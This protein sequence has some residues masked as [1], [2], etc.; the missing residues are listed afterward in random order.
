MNLRSKFARMGFR[1]KV[2]L[3]LVVC[4]LAAILVTTLGAF[5]F[6]VRSLGHSL[7]Q[8]H[9]TM[10]LLIADNLSAAV[11][12]N[13]REAITSILA[14]LE[15]DSDVV[16]ARVLDLGGT[17]LATVENP[18][19]RDGPFRH[20]HVVP[21]TVAVGTESLGLLEITFDDGPALLRL[22][23]VYLGLS[24]L[25]AAAAA[26]IA[27]MLGRIMS[28][29]VLAPISHLTAVA[30]SISEQGDSS[31]RA[32]LTENP[33]IDVLVGALNRMLDRIQWQEREL[34]GARDHLARQVVA[35]EHE[36]KQ[37]RRIQEERLVIE[38]KMQDSQRLE[39]LG[40]LAGG[41]A[42]DFNNLLAAILGN[43]NLAQMRLPE[44]SPVQRNLKQIET[45]STRAAELCR[46]MLAYAGRGPMQ[47]APVKVD[48][49][50]RET[51][52][53]LRV[54]IGA[55]CELAITSAPDLPA[56]LGDGSQLRQI[57]LNLVVNAAE[58]I[59]DA[60]L[61]QITVHV[62]Q[63]TYET[64]EFAHARVGR[65]LTTG[66]FVTIEVADNGP[67]MKA[68]VLE[69]IFEPF[70]STKFTGRG[71]GLA[72][73]LG[74]IRRHHGALFVTSVPGGG[75]TFRVV[76]P[77]VETTVETELV[78]HPAL[79]SNWRGSGR[80]LVVDDEEGARQ[81]EADFVEE[82]GFNAIVAS[83]GEEALKR[84]EEHRGDFAA[85][86]LDF[87]LPRMDGVELASLLRQ[88]HP[89]LP[90]LL[91]SGYAESSAIADL[92]PHLQR[93]FLSKPFT[94]RNFAAALRKTIEA[95]QA[96]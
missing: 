34:H 44:G 21:E 74:I 80:V 12:F 93:N 25:V 72:A 64:V 81:A 66:T 73:T 88:R 58:A 82:L 32:P 31:L 65:E 94:F 41:V 89:D 70:F 59:G 56:V 86:V 85:A 53:L 10:A 5:V 38:R 78:Q 26:G 95:E 22:S 24:A 15:A 11:A 49:L 27:I 79:A 6:Q 76:L 13:D 20:L 87:L 8:K 3:L 69:R 29:P 28:E 61:G 23:L 55:D 48:E 75:S 43:A 18:A 63:R 68:D 9:H 62:S 16:T 4:S 90:V 36:I 19:Y 47:L 96:E 50:V 67:G 83:S 1:P 14:S 7:H 60:R 39:S 57:V 30:H 42:H 33:D 2:R 37:R 91:L 45:I 46:Q 40:V 71:L 54:S 92:P 52:E 17:V 77:A 35:L 84:F 51:A